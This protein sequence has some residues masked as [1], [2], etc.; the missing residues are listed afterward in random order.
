MTWEKSTPTHGLHVEELVNPGVD[1]IGPPA[2]A[3]DARRVLPIS[4]SCNLS[5]SHLNAR[6]LAWTLGQCPAAWIFCMH[7][8]LRSQLWEPIPLPGQGVAP[9]LRLV[10]TATLRQQTPSFFT[11]SCPWQCC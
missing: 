11:D 10:D 1:I 5:V 2:R 8:T 3:K 9:K 7:T 6:G 4:N